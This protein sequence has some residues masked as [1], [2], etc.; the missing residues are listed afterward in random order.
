MQ[1]GEEELEEL[2]FFIG[3]H[4]QKHAQEESKLP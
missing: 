4:Q 2:S 1:H 3:R